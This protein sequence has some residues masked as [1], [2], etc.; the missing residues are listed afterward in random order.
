MLG[1]GSPWGSGERLFRL[2][3]WALTLDRFLPQPF[4]MRSSQTV[5]GHLLTSLSVTLK[6]H[7]SAN[8]FA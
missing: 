7:V 4:L 6:A 1:L 5:N 2:C 3:K 8:D